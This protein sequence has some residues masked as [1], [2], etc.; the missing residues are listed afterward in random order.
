[1]LKKACDEDKSGQYQRLLEQSR[2]GKVVH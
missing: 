2:E 1:M